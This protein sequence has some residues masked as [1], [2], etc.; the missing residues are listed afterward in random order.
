MLGKYAYCYVNERHAKGEFTRGTAD[1]T[2]Y[3]LADFVRLFGHRPMTQLTP[4]FID[5]WLAA[6][7]EWKPGTRRTHYGQVRAFCR[8]LHHRGVVRK[9]P[10]AGK[11]APKRPRRNPRPLTRHQYETLHASVP[12]ARARLIVALEYWLGLRACEVARLTLEDCD[13]H[14]NLMHVVGK[15]GHERTLP[16]VPQV[17]LALNLYLREHPATS[18]PLVRSYT[19]PGGLL[20]GTVSILV[21]SWLTA[22]GLKQSA[23]D[24]VTG[25][26]MRHSAATELAELTHDPYV[27]QELMGHADISTSM[28][29]V[30]RVDTSRL[31]EALSLRTVSV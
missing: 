16:V 14:H 11:T 6:H 1:R 24:G 25:H 28:Y 27:V 13:R 31:R 20:P 8:W 12:D 21:R 23:F 15:G 5:R 30:R 4:V 19:R 17:Q 10:F 29:Y 26:A 2:W 9:D 3:C 22:A 18:G 7:P